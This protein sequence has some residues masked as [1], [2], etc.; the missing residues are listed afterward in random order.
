MV[1]SFRG[2]PEGALARGGPPLELRGHREIQFPGVWAYHQREQAPHTALPHVAKC[3]I[4]A[5]R[6]HIVGSSHSSVTL[7]AVAKNDA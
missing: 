6:P 4:L 1:C 2:E 3:V 5:T 7:A